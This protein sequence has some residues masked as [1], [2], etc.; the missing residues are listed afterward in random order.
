MIN[1]F[2]WNKAQSHEII[3]SNAIFR[4]YEPFFWERQVGV[5]FNPIQ[6]NSSNDLQLFGS[7]YMNSWFF[8]LSITSDKQC[9]YSATRSAREMLI[10]DNQI[11]LQVY[12][13]YY[14]EFEHSRW[15]VSFMSLSS[16]RVN[17]SH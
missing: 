13:I 9:N 14:L 7:L 6:R 5:I 2:Q 11:V 17:L 8:F 16:R 3:F 12:M 15:G 10:Y 4:G 1:Y